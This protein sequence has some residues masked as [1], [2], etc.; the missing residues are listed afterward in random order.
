MINL[1]KHKVIQYNGFM[2]CICCKD[3]ND[4]VVLGNGAAFGVILA[5]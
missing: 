2:E 1:Q 4:F 3:V 5:T